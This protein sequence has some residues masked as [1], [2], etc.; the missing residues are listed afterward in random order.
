MPQ[1]PETPFDIGN[2]APHWWVKVVGMLQ[3]NWALPI[4]SETGVS[5]VFVGDTSG[6]F[7]RLEFKNESEMIR[8][9]HINNFEEFD[10]SPQL[11]E[12]LQ[13]PK[14]PLN[15]RPHPNGRIYSSGQYWRSE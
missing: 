10:R 12:F 9:L 6:I 11:K 1:L 8:A 2:E 14:F 4:V 15:D 3:Q 13:P 5:V 7:D